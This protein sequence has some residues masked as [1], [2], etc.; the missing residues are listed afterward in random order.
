PNYF[1]HCFRG[2]IGM[3]HITNF[4]VSYNFFNTITNWGIGDLKSILPTSIARIEY[5]QIVNATVGIVGAKNV[6][7]NDYIAY[8]KINSGCSDIGIELHE[9][10]NPPAAVYVVEYNEVKDPICIYGNG[11]AGANAYGNTLFLYNDHTCFTAPQY[12]YGINFTGCIKSSAVDNQITT[13]DLFDT[14]IGIYGY[15]SQNTMVCGNT[16]TNMSYGMNFIGNSVGTSIYNNTLYNTRAVEYG[17]Y[18]NVTTTLIEGG[19]SLPTYNAWTGTWGG[20]TCRTK[21]FGNQPIFYYEILL[22]YI[23][24]GGGCINEANGI[25]ATLDNPYFC[26]GAPPPIVLQK[27][28]L[29]SIATGNITSTQ[30]PDTTIAVAQQGLASIIMQTPSLLSDTTLQQFN[31]SIQSSPMGAVMQVDTM[32]YSPANWNTTTL[33]TLNA[34]TPVTNL[35]ANMQYTSQ[36]YLNDVMNDSLSINQLDS[37]RTLAAMCPLLNGVGVFRARAILVDYDSAGTFYLDTNCTCN[38]TW[39]AHNH[40]KH[41]NKTTQTDSTLLAKFN[42]YPNPNNGG[43]TLTYQLQ[44]GQAGTFAIFNTIGEKVASYDLDASTNTMKI[45]EEALNNGVYL[46]TIRVNNSVVKTDKLVIIK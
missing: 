12:E 14:T 39:N 5:N 24:T 27:A 4:N 38:K 15:H 3:E 45:D 44:S 9:V 35:D 11:L 28:I 36:G 37:L 18:F 16:D 8:N 43:F 23:P 32:T 17:M 46:Y 42:L 25:V 34:V 30:T 1:L 26:S 13:L 21:Y 19:T 22:K 20:A 31:D 2:V 41:T 40:S 33:A 7:I 6:A 10:S 29:D